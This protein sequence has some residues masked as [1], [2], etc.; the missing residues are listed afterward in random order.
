M[1]NEM[2]SGSSP[3]HCHL[4]LLGQVGAGKSSSGNTILG[5]RIFHSK[6]SLNAVTQD[7]Q[8]A[9]VTINGL[10]VDIYDTPGFL[11][12]G[13]Q[14]EEIEGKCQKLLQ[15]NSSA[16]TVFL[17]VISTDRFAEQEKKAA[18]LVLSFLGINNLQN[19]WIIF[20]KGDEL[21]S[22]ENTIE[23]YMEDSEEL[24]ELVLKLNN[25]YLVFNNKQSLSNR[26]QAEELMRKIK[27]NGKTNGIIETD[28]SFAQDQLSHT[29]QQPVGEPPN[30][31][32]SCSSPTAA[33]QTPLSDGNNNLPL[34]KI[35]LLG[36]TGVGKSATGNTI[37]GIEV[38]RSE[39]D[40]NAVTTESSVKDS[41]VFGRK[42]SVIDTPG[43]F[44]TKLE[45]NQLAKE[46]GSSLCQAEGGIDAFLLIFEYGRFTKQEANMLKRVETVFGK[47]VTKHI[48]IVFTH[49][50]ECDREK[51][52]SGIHKN[53]FLSGVINKCGQRYHIIDN[54]DNNSDQVSQLLQMID[55]MQ[56]AHGEGC[57]TNEMLKI[58]NM[59]SLEY[60]WHKLKEILK[61]AIQI[62]SG[63]SNKE[64][65]DPAQIKPLLT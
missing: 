32:Q 51:L 33:T 45:E 18:D 39:K 9:S 29:E 23:Q 16:P 3:P 52:D 44:D 37:L 2:Q 42:V 21:E 30:R 27:H 60:I 49:G 34:R 43:F 13:V 41:N 25:Q 38:F 10:S 59:G 63:S 31:D 8:R 65:P 15:L 48:I 19:T 22:D 58:A 20:T 1:N 47:H 36:K 26:K 40:V 14:N 64:M 57:Y 5:Q 12:P 62:L 50:D 17:W 4:V 46:F 35:M 56:E 54:K 28:L 53:E 55:S 61:K 7:V 6:K 24:K 11:G